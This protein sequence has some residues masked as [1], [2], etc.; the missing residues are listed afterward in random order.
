LELNIS[1][2]L[3]ISFIDL[4]LLAMLQEPATGL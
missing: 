3:A 4:I 2:L 1:P